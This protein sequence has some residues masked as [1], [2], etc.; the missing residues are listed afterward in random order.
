MGVFKLNVYLLVLHR[1]Q[2]EAC[3]ECEHQGQT[4]TVGD[5]WRS[6]QCKLCQ[7]LPNLTVQ[8]A[9]Y[10]PYAATGCPQV[11][12]IIIF[13]Q[14]TK[15]HIKN[16]SRFGFMWTQLTVFLY[17]GSKFGSWRRRQMLLLPRWNLD[18]LL[19]WHFS[20][21]K[22]VTFVLLPSISFVGDKASVSVTVS[23]SITPTPSG[24]NIPSVPTYPLPPGGECF[25]FCRE[26]ECCYVIS[27]SDFSS[28]L[29]RWVLVSSGCSVSA[30]V[31]LHRIL[32][33][34]WSPAW[35]SASLWLGFAQWPPGMRSGGWS[36]TLHTPKPVLLHVL[37]SIN[38]LVELRGTWFFWR[39]IFD[40]RK[41]P[42]I[43][44][45]GSLHRL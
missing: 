41:V 7:C 6:E 35:S 30:S 25:L 10:C 23:P 8:C 9:P 19:K 15:H 2:T 13:I 29:F 39:L 22:K 32:A 26:N 3:H 24:D 5:R 33:A 45:C 12:S 34:G 31:K 16:H 38:S 36:S 27:D 43:L 44:C 14:Y 11:K 42:S 28:S 21:C 37:Y 20:K 17:E 18:C 1:C 4:H 40:S